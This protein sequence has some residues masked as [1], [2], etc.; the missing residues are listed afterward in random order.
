M[1]FPVIYNADRTRRVVFERNAD[2]SIGFRED[3]WS[4]DRYEHCWIPSRWPDSHCDTMETA[5]REA[6]GRLSWLSELNPDEQ[7]QL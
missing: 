6:R 4:N 7:A 3:V 1:E 2:G 5:M